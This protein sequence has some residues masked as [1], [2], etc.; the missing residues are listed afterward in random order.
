MN[1]EGNKCATFKTT[2][3]LFLLSFKSLLDLS[4][5]KSAVSSQMVCVG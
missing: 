5:L 2:V 1:A 3:F 4:W